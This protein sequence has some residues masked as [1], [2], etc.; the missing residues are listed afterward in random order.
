MDLSGYYSYDVQWVRVEYVWYYRHV[1]FD[2]INKMPVAEL[3]SDNENDET[4]EKFIDK[5]IP[6][7][8]RTAIIT[9]LKKSYDKIIE[10]L[11]FIHQKCTFHLKLNIDEK[12]KR[13]LNKINKNMQEN[14]K[15]S[16][17][18]PPSTK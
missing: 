17:Q 11:G 14:T 7:H 13:Y 15:N 1:L 12:I 8:K 10:K 18:M 3:L 4:V 6:P 9:D 5:N 2:L 16:S